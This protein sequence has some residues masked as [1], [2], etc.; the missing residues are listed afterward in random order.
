[1]LRKI[2]ITSFTFFTL[3]FYCQ[4]KNSVKIHGVISDSTVRSIRYFDLQPSFLNQFYDYNYKKV[5]VVDKQVNLSFN[6]TQPQLLNISPPGY[7][8]SQTVFITPGDSVSF[9]IKSSGKN[10]YYLLFSGKNAAHYNFSNLVRQQFYVKERPIYHKG[11]DLMLYKQALELWLKKKMEFLSKYSSDNKLS[12]MFLNYAKAEILNN[13]I[14][15]LYLPLN[16][17][18]FKN[19][20]M[21]QNYFKD[22]HLEENSLSNEY[23]MALVYKYIYHYTENPLDDFDLVYSNIKNNFTK[24]TR[25]FLLSSMIGYYSSNQQ[26]NYEKKLLNAIRQAP[27]F[28]SDSSY[29][30]YIKTCKEFYITANRPF[31]NKVLNNTWLKPLNGGQKITLVQL[32]DKFKGKVLYI[33]FW[34]S[35]CSA[36]RQDIADSKDTKQFL[37]DNKVEWIYISTDKDE[38]AWKNASIK[39]GTTNNQY[40]LLDGASSNLAKLLNITS[41]PRYLLIDNKGKIAKASAPRPYNK[42]LKSVVKKYGQDKSVIT[43]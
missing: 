12:D 38:K 25:S 9:E 1:M 32:L 42:E 24:Q 30:E 2:L 27:E 34:A 22:V 10:N 36:C 13:F 39:D 40:L 3:L 23:K 33:D 14:C 35:W 29:L 43:Y 5:M 21:P 17:Y 6:I 26:I 11:D 8:W 41:I 4:S 7:S 31:P 15:D 37:F 16:I 19:R 20:E 18:S 28:I